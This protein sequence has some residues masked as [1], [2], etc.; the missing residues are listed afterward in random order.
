MKKYVLAVVLM[1]MMLVAACGTTGWVCTKMTPDKFAKAEF[2][3]EKFQ[4]NYTT[5][6]GFADVASSGAVS[7]DPK[8]DFWVKVAGP[9]LISLADSSLKGL[10]NMIATGCVDDVTMSLAQVNADKIDTTLATQPA[11]MASMKLKM[12]AFKR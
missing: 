6:V 3:L 9:L 12:K 10:G 1:C 11:Q 8:V 7:G 4:A 2:L 5:L